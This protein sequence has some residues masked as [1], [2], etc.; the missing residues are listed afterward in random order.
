MEET[1]EAPDQISEAQFKTT[2]M[3]LHTARGS[4]A[5]LGINA[6]ENPIRELEVSIK[7]AEEASGVSGVATQSVFTQFGHL[8]FARACQSSQA[9]VGLP[10]S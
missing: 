7:R 6:L 4:A 10:T 5:M 9:L 2:L 8:G 3:H 1:L